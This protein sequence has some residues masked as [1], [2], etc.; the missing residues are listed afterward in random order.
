MAAHGGDIAPPPVSVARLLAAHDFWVAILQYAQGRGGFNALRK[1]SAI[2]QATDSALCLR[3][4]IDSLCLTIGDINC[5]QEC[6]DATSAVYRATC[7]DGPML[8]RDVFEPVA[9]WRECWR[10]LNHFIEDWC[11]LARASDL[12]AQVR[13]WVAGKAHGCVN[14]MYD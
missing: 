2:E 10:R 7:P 14:Y 13:A 4:S 1:C 12:A 9:R 6:W 8:S 3:Q 5:L 11:S